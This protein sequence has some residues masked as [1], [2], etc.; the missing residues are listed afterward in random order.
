VNQQEPAANRDV[1]TRATR[2]GLHV[3]MHDFHFDRGKHVIDKANMFISK[4]ATIHQSAIRLRETGSRL[5]TRDFSRG[6]RITR[7]W[8]A[9]PVAMTAPNGIGNYRPV[10]TKNTSAGTNDSRRRQAMKQERAQRRAQLL[11]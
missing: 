10:V 3:P 8:R 6:S 7:A 2:T 1:V 11:I 5:R 4:F 9:L